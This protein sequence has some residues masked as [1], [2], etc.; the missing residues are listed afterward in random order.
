MTND[1][2]TTSPP[3]VGSDAQSPTLDTES[4]VRQFVIFVCGSE[5]FGVDMAPVQEIIRVPDVVRVPL[6]PGSL[7]G[8]ANLRGKVL[9]IISLRDLFGFDERDNDDASRALV[10]D[11]GQPLGFVVDRVSSVV[12]VEPEQIE[13][14]TG[15]STTVNT[16][17]LSGLLKNVGGFEMVMVMDFKRLIGLELTEIDQLEAAAVAN[18]TSLGEDGAAR[19]ETDATQDELQ[20]VSFQVAEQEYAIPIEH[21]QEIVQLPEHIVKVPRTESHVLGLMNL[22]NRLLPLVSLRCLLELPVRNADE[23]SRIVVVRLGNVTVG[24]VMDSVNEVLR[25]PTSVVEPMPA[26]LA[27][28]GNLQE[29]TEICRLGEDGRRLVSIISIR[30]LFRHSAIQEALDSVSMMQASDDPTHDPSAD[31]TGRNE[32]AGQ[33]DD[34]E[35]VVVFRLDKEE[36][37]VPIASVQEIVRVPDELTHVPKAPAFVEGVINLRGSVLPVIDQ[38]RRLGLP[39]VEHNDRQRIM[40]FLLDGVRIGFI[41]DLVTEVLKIPQ[42]AIEP[43]PHLS[44]E[45]AMLINRVANMQQQQRLIQLLDPTHLIAHEQRRELAGLTT[46]PEQLEV[47]VTE[48]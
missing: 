47:A 32:K 11:L 37:G 18:A 22:R 46:H 6:G 16:E 1:T 33:R 34:E 41:V 2:V 27:V 42:A 15:L 10:I 3:A 25:V 39:A 44:A 38:R 31:L 43:A 26:L 14:V 48:A 36:F 5:V 35:Q 29:I 28:S 30:N 21:T 13:D 40:V 20:L 7:L 45:Q 19:E 17:M 23:H 24:L 12:A 8:L 9:P 4:A